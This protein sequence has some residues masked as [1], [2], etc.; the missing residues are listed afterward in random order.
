MLTIDDI[1][2]SVE[3]RLLL[4]G[5]SAR[6][7][8]GHKVGLIGRN[9]TGKTT[10]FRLIRGELALEGGAIT[11]PQRARIGGV[12]QEVPA[13]EVSLLDTVL[14]ADTERAALMAEAEEA[15]DA[16]RIAEV[17]TR[18]ADI[19]AWSAEA[20]A[21]SIL[22]GLGFDDAEQLMPCS[23]FSGGWRMRVALAGVLF[24]QPDLLLLDE[25]TNYLD[26]EGALWL[27]SYLAKYPHTVIII[28]H[29]RGLLNR[30]VGAI[31]HL[32]DRQLTFYQ[33]PY[34]QFARQRAEQRA[35]QASMAKKQQARVAHL[36]S[37][38]DR[39]RAK[40]SKAKQAQARLKMIEKIDLVAAPEEVAR[41]VFTF[42]QPEELSPPIISIEGGETGYDDKPVLRGLNLRID[43]DDRIA[44]LGKN[45]Q[46]KSTLSKLLSDRL[47]LMA[48]KM[49]RSAKLRI[50]YF[51]QHQVDE[52][53]ID[54]TP[55]QHLQRERPETQQSKLRAQ[56]AGFGLGAD[57]AETEVGRLSGGQKARLSLLLATLDAPHLLI[58]D[59]PTN[60]LDI[61]SREALVEALTAYGGA[62]IL[63]SHDM[64]L[65][66]MV[67]D[68]LWLVSDGGVKPFDDDLEAY[69]KL[70]LSSDKPAKSDKPKPAKKDEAPRRATREKLMALRAEVRK[71]E[72]RVEK[73][74]DMHGKLSRKLADPA[75]YDAAKTAELAEWNRKFAEVEEGLKR[76]EALWMAALEKLEKVGG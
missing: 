15:V 41:R 48:G 39:F 36:Q 34:D 19:D 21:S 1:S 7:P 20:R 72:D 74:T 13:N 75:I 33:G 27:E 35:V 28:S 61:E 3:G 50:G 6:I 26:L 37:F 29:D 8:A 57:Q 55:L 25:P 44:L 17:Q 59:E 2:Y 47:P 68:R 14:A 70:L 60:H 22:K 32:E 4:D 46:G 12:A 73:I 63:V 56:L 16:T 24:A 58:L 9:G 43:H 38:V 53:H 65:L 66:S 67:A 49:T 62:V 64:H 54:E 30:A 40:A 45:G 18:L 5:A 71:C 11:L 52:L 42:P 51:A 31:L 10:L 69:R 76:A 23:A